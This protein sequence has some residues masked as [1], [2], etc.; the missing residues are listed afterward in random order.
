MGVPSPSGQQV[1]IWASSQGMFSV[2]SSVSEALD[3]PPRQVRVESVPI[4]GAFGGKFGL[5]EPL[6]AA[7]AFASRRPV[8]LALSRSEDLLAGNP[9]PPAARNPKL[10][11]RRHPPLRAGT[12]K[13]LFV[14]HA[15]T[16]S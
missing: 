1:T 10:A 12:A 7:A 5:V 6:A 15:V 2:R 4:G 14:T 8:R 3:L 16:R 13:A 11:A 9:A